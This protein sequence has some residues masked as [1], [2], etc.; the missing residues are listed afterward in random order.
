MAARNKWTVLGVASVGTLSSTLDG[1]AVSVIYPALATAFDTDTSTVLWVTV[2]YWVTAV[3]LLLTMG[4]LSDVVGRRRVFIAG[5]SLFALGILLSSLSLNIWQLIAFR[6][7]QGVGSSM[8]LA[9]LN[10]LITANFQAKERGKALG[11]SGAVVGVGLTTGPLIGG[12][13]LDLMDWRAVFYTRAPIA[14][15]GA[16]LAWWLLPRDRVEGPRFRLDVKRRPVKAVLLLREVVRYR[17]NVR[18]RRCGPSPFD[19]EHVAPLVREKVLLQVLNEL[20]FGTNACVSDSG[21]Q[22]FVAVRDPQKIH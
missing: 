4:W 19:V 12:V 13:L 11:V 18:Q 1:G 6:V 21:V 8:L 10:A 2:A 14:A 20:G 17:R 15:A 7:F 9:S 16:V 5:S 22:P 3:G